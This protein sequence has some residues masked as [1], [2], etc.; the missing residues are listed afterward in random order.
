MKFLCYLFLGTDDKK[1]IKNIQPLV[2]STNL[3]MLRGSVL[4]C[5]ILIILQLVASIFV[6]NLR[7]RNAAYFSLSVLYLIIFLILTFFQTKSKNLILPMFYAVF[8]STLILGIWIGVI[9]PSARDYTAVTFNVLLFVFP[10]LIADYPWR[11]DLILII[12]SICFLK[13]SSMYK[14]PEVFSIELANVINSLMLSM[15]I[16]TMFQIKNIKS[17]KYR[18]SLKNQRDTDVLSLTLSRSA[19]ERKMEKVITTNGVCGCFMFVDIDNFKHINDA[20]GHAIGDEFI[21]ETATAIRSVCRQD[22]IVGRYGGDEFL[23]FFPYMIQSSVVEQKACAI[24]SSVK[25]GTMSKKLQQSLSVSIGCLT[26]KNPSLGF[27]YLFAEVDELLY[28]AKRDGKNT[29][30]FK[31]L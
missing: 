18:L 16:S 31:A 9:E 17:F 25:T 12:A 15:A 19:L 7:I 1:T 26:F 13:L 2:H 21:A 30:R 5:S 22:D 28:Q 23:I 20:F 6:P 27:K 4:T 14:T 3:Q 24:L 29:F 10:L 8:I 11:L